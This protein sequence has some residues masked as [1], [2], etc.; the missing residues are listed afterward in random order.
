MEKQHNTYFE[1]GRDRQNVSQ[2]A[3]FPQN[4]SSSAPDR[5]DWRYQNSETIG[6][7]IALSWKISAELHS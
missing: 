5:S 2:T 1:G 6:E 7:R 4:P 3:R